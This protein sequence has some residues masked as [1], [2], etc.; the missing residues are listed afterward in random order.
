MK[1]TLLVA[2]LALVAATSNGQVNRPPTPPQQ[3]VVDTSLRLAVPYKFYADAFLTDT[4][5][6]VAVA[7][8][9]NLKRAQF[10]W[11]ITTAKKKALRS[12]VFP[13]AGSCYTLWKE[14]GTGLAAAHIV[15]D[16]VMHRA[17]AD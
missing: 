10:T 15:A 9:D 13:C 11:Y 1:K 7:V 6:N 5:T 16:S 17:L 2:M 4:A 14:D 12:G 3:A 8:I